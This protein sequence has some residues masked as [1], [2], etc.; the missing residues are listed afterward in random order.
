MNRV[1]AD[2]TGQ[3]VADAPSWQDRCGRGRER[4]FRPTAGNRQTILFCLLIVARNSAFHSTSSDICKTAHSPVD[5]EV[6]MK[7]KSIRRRQERNHN[8]WIESQADI[9]YV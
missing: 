2:R 7:L 1:S 5:L 8:I 9:I 6:V 3:P 4:L